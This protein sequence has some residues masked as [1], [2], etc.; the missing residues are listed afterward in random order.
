MMM[1]LDGLD[2]FDC[3]GVGKHAIT[4]GT[5]QEPPVRDLNVKNTLD[6]LQVVLSTA[7]HQVI[8]AIDQKTNKTF[9]SMSELNH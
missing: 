2:C 1:G 9:W 7:H 4:N 8:L 5:I 3:F 6:L